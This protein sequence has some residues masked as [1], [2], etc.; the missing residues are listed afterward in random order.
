MPLVAWGLQGIGEGF[1]L[2]YALGLVFVVFSRLGAIR[3]A[4]ACA[5]VYAFA[6]ML[7]SGC[8]HV[9]P[10]YGPHWWNCKNIVCNQVAKRVLGAAY[11]RNRRECECYI[12]D[13]RNLAQWEAVKP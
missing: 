10:V 1:A 11:D 3:A 4:L 7:S 12:E 6:V 13:A 9:E 2:A 5:F 8:A